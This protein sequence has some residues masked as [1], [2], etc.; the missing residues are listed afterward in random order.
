MFFFIA[1]MLRIYG[2]LQL[3]L[4]VTQ[5]KNRF[6]IIETISLLKVLKWVFS[7]LV[8]VYSSCWY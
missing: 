6:C 7:D 5:Y 2:L 4:W 3:F 8:S 1:A